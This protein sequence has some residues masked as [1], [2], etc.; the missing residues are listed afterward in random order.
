MKLVQGIYHE[1]REAHEV[2]FE[3]GEAKTTN[4]ILPKTPLPIR[5]HLCSSVVLFY[6]RGLRALRGEVN[7]LPFVFSLK[8]FMVC[9]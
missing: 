5:V 8:S 9:P 7:R 2:I 1:A 3:R 4:V 6:L